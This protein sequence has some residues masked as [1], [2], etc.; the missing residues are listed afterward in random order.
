MNIRR[1]TQLLLIG[2]AVGMLAGC[3]R[4]EGAKTKNTQET[5]AETKETET[6]L[7]IS[8]EETEKEF[9]TQTPTDSSEASL[10]AL[11]EL[12]GMQD[13]YT[14]GLF[15]GGEENRNGD[16]FIGRIYNVTLEGENYKAHTTVGED[17]TVES[18][19]LW[20]VSGERDVTDEEAKLW[21]ERMTE[22][23]GAEPSYDDTSSEA[24]SKNWRWMSDG[25]SAG[26]NRMKD[27]LTISFQTAVGELK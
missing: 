14:S 3:G 17:G 27:I 1:W 21:E 15:G 4:D 8:T 10:E 22:L 19:S 26:M 23:M 11:K 5:V 18:V 20:I 13:K 9:E 25:I 12:V 7:E 6:V 2:M 16:F 24:G